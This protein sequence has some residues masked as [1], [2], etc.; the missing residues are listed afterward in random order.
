LAKKI[1]RWCH[2]AK[3]GWE[4]ERCC[5]PRNKLGKEWGE[6]VNEKKK[7]FGKDKREIA[8]SR[9]DE[10]EESS[11]LNTTTDKKGEG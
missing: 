10:N 4:A 3:R 7:G 11:T 5:S 6:K 8:P 1:K 2:E 9:R